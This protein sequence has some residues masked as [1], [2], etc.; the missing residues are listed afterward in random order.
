MARKMFVPRSILISDRLRL[1]AC[2]SP[3]AV[4]NR[5]VG[6]NLPLVSAYSIPLFINKSGRECND[7]STGCKIHER[8]NRH[9]FWRNSHLQDLSTWR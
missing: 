9:R 7:M 1:M 5:Y 6:E 4:P 2:R 3:L 8:L